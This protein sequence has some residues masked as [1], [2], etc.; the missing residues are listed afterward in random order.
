[1][2]SA[3]AE[4]NGNF[5]YIISSTVGFGYSHFPKI[6]DMGRNSQTVKTNQKISCY[7][8]VIVLN[9]RES[10]CRTEHCVENFWTNILQIF[11]KET[12][13]AD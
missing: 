5:A 4:F 2:S 8:K 10:L 3:L 1:M 12:L 11:R 9:L 13:R 7:F 6:F